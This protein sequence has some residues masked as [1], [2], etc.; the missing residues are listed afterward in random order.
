MGRKE[1]NYRHRKYYRAQK[2]KYPWLGSYRDA[3]QRCVNFNNPSYKS[4]GGR[5]IEF[6]L[7]HADM[8]YLWNRDQA[9][10][11]NKPSIDRKNG[12]GHYTRGNCRF[13]EL[14]KNSAGSSSIMA[15]SAIIIERFGKPV[16]QL[17]LDGSFIAEFHSIHD[18]ARTTGVNRGSIFE[19]ISG[20]R[21]RRTAGG[22]IWGLHG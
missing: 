9:W 17:S 14:C 2:A 8:D 1:Y 11:L 4:Y 19:C 12:D 10:L 22:F 18:A 21:S 15:N 13:I 5:G 3:K 16:V 7:T 20:K 6:H